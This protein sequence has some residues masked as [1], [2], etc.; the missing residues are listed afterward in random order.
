MTIEKVVEKL[1]EERQK[2]I[3]SRF[4]CR[5]IM[6]DDIA[7]Y[8]KLISEL[9]KISD[10]E[11]VSSNELFAS[12]DVMPRYENLKNPS[13]QN[14]WMILTG[15]SEY[16][17]LFSKSEAA[18]QRFAKL[19][20]YQAPANSTGRILIPLWGCESQWH[21]KSLHLCEDIRQEEFYYD[22]SD[23]NTDEQK[24]SI[25]VLSGVFEQYMEQLED[26][27]DKVYVGLQEWFEYWASPDSQRTE[28]V[29]LTKRVS[30]IQATNAAI[31]VRVIQ[32]TLSFVRENLING[33]DLTPENCPNAVVDLLFDYALKRMTVDQAILSAL[34]IAVFS[35][36]DVAAKWKSMNEGHKKLVFLW[37]MLHPDNTYLCQC[38]KDS[39]HIDEVPER[40]LHSIF[41]FRNMHPHWVEE[42]RRLIKAF[43]VAKNSKFFDELDKIPVYEE[44]LKYLS[45]DSREEC[46]Y[47]LRML[48]K[49]MREDTNQVLACEEIKQSY[50]EIYAYLS[51]ESNVLGADLKEYFSLYKAYKL[52]NTLPN[53]EEV[54]FNGICTDGFDYRFK[55]LNDALDD[56]CV[57]L[58]IDA[59][60][61]EWTSLLAWVLRQCKDCSIK[62][63]TVAQATLPTETCFNSQWHEMNVPYKKLDKLDKLAHKGVIDDPDYYA[64]IADQMAFV[65]SLKDVV[66][67]L[68]QTYHRV[69][70]VGD[71]GTSRLAARFFHKRNGMLV[72]NG[73][74]VHSHGRYCKLGSDT[75]LTLANTREV[76]DSENNKYLVFNNYDHFVQS[77]F[78]AGANDDVAIFGEVHGGST[79][80]EM[81]VPLIVVDSTRMVHLEACWKKN[82][83]KIIA[84][85]IK[86]SLEF[87][88]VV[89]Q[90]HA[91]I[92]STDAICTPSDDKKQWNLQFAGISAGVYPVTITADGTAVGVEALIVKSAL[93][94]GDGD[95]P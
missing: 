8:K 11:V 63:I 56:D 43:K 85:K 91:R 33:K 1:K 78:A 93:G 19:W 9:Q 75:S 81:L 2:G 35:D 28:Y 88:R 66:N 37:Y 38:I 84:K 74:S 77:G 94:D 69:I 30:S 27:D 92:S 32:D 79:P 23:E 4:P 68:L 64:C 87:N 39:K 89:H 76:K 6:V 29:L 5:A 83:V 41:A 70:I 16:L 15:V 51:D 22:C 14:R 60:G 7:Q 20:S 53:D 26:L 36:V 73:A 52:E 17:R 65:S 48:G 46:I 49:W 86:T 40:V 18:T 90:L 67:E 21:D 61:A 31:S 13:Y 47:L 71:H 57:V 50:P 59:L 25:L 34:N 10:V 42:S 72:P 54:Y 58:W 44:R 82:P 62:E 55:C 95:L 45:G 24:M 3:P 80:E 12:A